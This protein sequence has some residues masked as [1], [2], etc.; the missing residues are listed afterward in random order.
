MC[1]RTSTQRANPVLLAEV[2]LPDFG[3]I[4]HRISMPPA[5]VK[6]LSFRASVL[7]ASV[8]SPET[9]SLPGRQRSHDYN[10]IQRIDAESWGHTRGRCRVVNPHRGCDPREG[11]RR[12]YAP[13][14]TSVSFFS[15]F[16]PRPHP[17]I[18]SWESRYTTCKQRRRLRSAQSR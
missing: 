7:P 6:R 9:L 2:Q 14:P 17:S 3:T 16:D 1:R 13:S 12:E 15:F 8:F 11:G 10:A 4:G 18:A 5:R